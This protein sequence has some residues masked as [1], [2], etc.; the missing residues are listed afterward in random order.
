MT[1]L[2]LESIENQIGYHFKKS[3]L[4]CQA[5]T[6]KSYA[7]ENGGTSNEVL[8]FLGD[9][10]LDFYVSKYLVSRYGFLRNDCEFVT[11]NNIDEKNLT[12]IKK[13]IV[14]NK[15]L[16]KLIEQWGFQEYLFLGKGDRKKEIQNELKVKADL[17]EAIL[18]A[19]AID[20]NWDPSI[21][22][23]MVLSML[24]IESYFDNN[25]EN[26]LDYIALIQHW[27][28]V[29][30]GCLPNYNILPIFK[31]Y[32]AKLDFSYNNYKKEFIGEG[33]SKQEARYNCAKVLYEFLDKNDL[34]ETIKSNCPNEEDLTNDN[35]INVLQELAQK[36]YCSMPKYTCLEKPYYDDDGSPI[37]ECI[38]NVESHSVRC[39]ACC[40]SKKEAKKYSFYLCIC[41]MM[42]YKDRYN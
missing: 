27:W 25:C 24:N 10:V 7:Q 2:N 33:F 42:G 31:S 36:G 18:G 12:E 8:E 21:L 22:E 34:L 4:L 20:S 28:Q 26:S 19:I 23:K 5:F 38:C 40:S 15:N 39:K 13:R 9:E 3:G 35:A 30:K 32:K 16:S 17:F 29:N 6:R 41:K 14:D 1:E 37:W 11:K